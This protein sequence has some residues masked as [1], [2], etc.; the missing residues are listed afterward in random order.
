MNK[1]ITED[2]M[3]YMS[4]RYGAKGRRSIRFSG[5]SN[6]LDILLGMKNA[7]DMD[8]EDKKYLD[9]DQLEELGKLIDRSRYKKEDIEIYRI[10]NT[11]DETT[12][13]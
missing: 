12:D 1:G 3:R 7:Q 9:N 10:F 11:R 6:E 5:R 2:F 13:Y 4:E 8:D